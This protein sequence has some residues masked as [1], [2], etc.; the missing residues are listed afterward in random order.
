MALLKNIPNGFGSTTSY[1]RVGQI[2]ISFLSKNV[3][4]DL[5]G[6]LDRQARL[7]GKQPIDQRS[8][9]FN[10]DEFPFNENE[11][12]NEREIAY[13]K[14]KSFKTKET[15]TDGDGTTRE[16]ETD[17]EFIDATDC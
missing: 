5:L 1:W 15:I 2:N 13:L 8:F 7:D 16:V 17:G 4:V 14:I 11:P 6:Y 10:G 3:H 9:D 12:Q